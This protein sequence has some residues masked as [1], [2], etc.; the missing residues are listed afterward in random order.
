MTYRDSDSH[1]RVHKLWE[2]C[3]RFHG[4]ACSELALGVRACDTALTKLALREADTNRLVCVCENDGCC[5]DAIQVGLHCTT[6]KKH[7]SIKREIL[8]LQSTIWSV[9]ALFESAPSR[10]FPNTSTVC[11][12]RIFWQCRRIGCSP[13]KRRI[14]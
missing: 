3:V 9:A 12:Q 2:H 11:N 14:L 7:L 13:L 5:V 10:R 4:K 6:G 1:D 8:F